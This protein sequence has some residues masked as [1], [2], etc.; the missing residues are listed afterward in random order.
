MNTLEKMTSVILIQSFL[1]NS[2]IQLR[3][4]AKKWA[5][6][7]P[8]LYIFSRIVTQLGLHVDPMG[9]CFPGL[10]GC[11]KLPMTLCSSSMAPR[12]WGSL[13]L[14]PPSVGSSTST[15]G[16]D[17]STRHTQVAVVQY[18]ETP[19]LEI[20]LGKHENSQEL[21]EAITSISYL[22]GNTRTGRAISSP[23]TTSSGCL[24]AHPSLPETASPWFSLTGVHR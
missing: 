7:C 2:S 9:K 8:L 11:S 16:F 18:S 22:G 14:K 24:T 6:V 5:N 1:C 10:A 23:Q 12:A 17:V 20:P 3:C 21:I 4:Q 19:R 15:S 13:I